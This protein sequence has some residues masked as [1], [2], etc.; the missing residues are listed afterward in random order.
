MECKE[1]ENQQ[2]LNDDY[3]LINDGSNYGAYWSCI[4]C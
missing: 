2:A 3:L 1:R 4:C